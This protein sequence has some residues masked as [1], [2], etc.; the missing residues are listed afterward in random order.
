MKLTAS[1]V[2]HSA[3]IVRSPSFSR[4]S[5]STTSTI[6]PRRM[7]SQC[8]VD[9]GERHRC[10]PRCGELGVGL[11]GRSRGAGQGDDHAAAVRLAPLGVDLAAV[12]VDDPA[13]DREAEAGAA[14]AGRRGRSRRGRSARRP[15][16]LVGSGMP[17]PS[18]IT[19]MV[20]PSS[21]RRRARTSTVAAARRV[22]HRV[23][24]Q[25][26][27]HL[28]HA[29]GVAV[30]REVGRRRPRC[31]YVDR[32]ARAAAARAPRARAAARPRTPC[33]RAARVPDSSRE[34]SSS[35]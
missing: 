13:R 16:R 1:G 24:E 27:D 22:A 31:R 21:A 4:S 6:S 26:R 23:L 12:E 28:V 2:T 18:S 34:R 32:R 3:A 5:S 14:V 30:G 35:C 7:R 29:L 19:S 17:G 8:F 33:G 9:G 11:G 15:G 10:P 25:V 20:T